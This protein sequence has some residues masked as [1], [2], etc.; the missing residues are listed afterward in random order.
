MSD[1]QELS[2]WFFAGVS[3]LVNGVLVLGAGVYEAVVPP[4]VPLVLASLHAPIWW[5]ALMLILGAAYTI[6]FAPKRASAAAAK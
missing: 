6:R 4:A 5:G 1:Y 3:L 2:I